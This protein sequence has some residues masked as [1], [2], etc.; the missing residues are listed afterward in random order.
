MRR[1]TGPLVP[2]AAA[3][4]LVAGAAGP[5]SAQSPPATSRVAWADPALFAAASDLGNLH[6][7]NQGDLRYRWRC[8]A[9][10]VDLK[11]RNGHW[12]E[13]EAIQIRDALDKL[14][15]LY[16]RK[17][18]EG[19][20]HCFYRDGRFPD[21]PWQVF[22]PPHDPLHAV[23][24]PVWPWNCIAI[25]DNMFKEDDF[26]VYRVVAHELGH[27]NQ[28]YLSGWATPSIGTPGF[29]KISWTTG[30]PTLGM[31]RWN[32]F[33]TNY[34]RTNHL[35]DFAE[36]A[37]FYWI[38]P[39]ELRRISPEKFA[40]MRDV[41]FEGLVSPPEARSNE[42]RPVDPVVPSIT[43]LG[44]RDDDWGSLVQVHGNYFMGPFDG[45]FNRVRYRGRTA[46]HVPVSRSTIYSF[47]PWIEA[48]SAPITVET[49]DGTSAAAAFTV[50]EPWW[51]FW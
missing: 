30:V 28:W 35:E 17:A 21:A 8:G 25:G 9:I 1:K 36:T 24:I 26:L 37:K 10:T 40:F 15:D 46:R 39:E 16:I 49:P 6:E 51:K 42:Q 14:P 33:V 22:A 18:I 41:V 31:R 44:D 12:T 2:F 7:V 19:G 20:V 5:A 34:A 38:A 11:D 3:A 47:V 23:T 27:A 29:T 32:G 45:G 50:D 48:G 43:S 13:H 4:L